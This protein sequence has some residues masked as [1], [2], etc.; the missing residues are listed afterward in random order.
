M[1]YNTV[2]A[3]IQNLTGLTPSQA[4]LCKTAGN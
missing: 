2:L 3:R 4:E 1:K